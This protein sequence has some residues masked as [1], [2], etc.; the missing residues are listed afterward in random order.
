MTTVLACSVEETTVVVNEVTG[1]GG[2]TYSAERRMESYD[3]D[4]SIV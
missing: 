3:D 4:E 1:M 2:C